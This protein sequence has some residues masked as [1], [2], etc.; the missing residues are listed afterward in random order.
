M[1][2]T[3]RNQN[4][5]SSNYKATENGDQNPNGV[6]ISCWVFFL[7]VCVCVCVFVWCFVLLLFCFFLSL[8]LICQVWLI[9]QKPI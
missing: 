9:E 4:Q 6:V 3:H 1:I 2:Q 7:C 5:A 8:S